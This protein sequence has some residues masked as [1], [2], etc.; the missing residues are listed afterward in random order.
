[1]I[2][3]TARLFRQIE[4]DAKAGKLKISNNQHRN[5]KPISKGSAD[6]KSRGDDVA[7]RFSEFVERFSRILESGDIARRTTAGAQVL[8]LDLIKSSAYEDLADIFEKLGRGY[9]Y[10][11]AA[12]EFIRIRNFMRAA[13]RDFPNLEPAIVRMVRGECRAISSKLTTWL[14]KKGS[15]GTRTDT[16][17]GWFHFHTQSACPRTKVSQGVV[18]IEHSVTLSH[19]HNRI[20][21]FDT[22]PYDILDKRAP[23][24]VAEVEDFLRHNFVIA[25][26]HKDEDKGIPST[27]KSSMPEEWR[28]R[29]S[30]SPQITS[31]AIGRYPHLKV[32][33]GHDDVR[34]DGCRAHL[35]SKKSRG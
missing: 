33:F 9:D 26:L 8:F 4:K 32:V 10:G 24:T 1:M 18:T 25:R 29:T 20:L 30:A 16:G 13:T 5:G 27:Y 28:W 6:I 31:A 35:E 19:I 11:F 12:A 23:E 21:G 2:C 7:E 17:N 14:V 22:K 34:C 3:L 15:D